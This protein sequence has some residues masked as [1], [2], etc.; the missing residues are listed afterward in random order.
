MAESILEDLEPEV[1]DIALEFDFTPEEIEN[2]NAGILLPALEKAL[3][4]LEVLHP[5]LK[6]FLPE[7][8]SNLD[9]AIFAI[10]TQ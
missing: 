9:D 8:P 6:G 5:D 7:V 4:D 3:A 2:M 10:A 1:I